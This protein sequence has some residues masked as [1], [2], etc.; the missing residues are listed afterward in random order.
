MNIRA[1]RR[2]FWLTSLAALNANAQTTNEFPELIPPYA[3]LPPTFWQQ[4]GP[5]LLISIFAGLIAIGL[6][7]WFILH[8]KQVPIPPPAVQARRALEALRT[9]PETGE[10]LSAVSQVLRRY[11]V[12]A[13]GN[14]PIEL[15]TFELEKLASLE[16]RISE[17]LRNSLVGFLKRCDDLKFCRSPEVVESKAVVQ[18]VALLERLEDCRTDRART[19]T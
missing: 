19:A 16:Q 5:V 18:A 9:Q 8:P 14:E 15:T 10:S 11:F 1:A 2:L 3:E 4:H 7:A 17:D 12:M 6:V 13:F